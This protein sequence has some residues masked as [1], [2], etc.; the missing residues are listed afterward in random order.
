LSK[1][2]PFC[3]FLMFIFAL[4]KDRIRGA[5]RLAKGWRI[6]VGGV[7]VRAAILRRVAETNRTR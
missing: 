4:S 6:V 3:W 1:D 5:S 7:I 2:I